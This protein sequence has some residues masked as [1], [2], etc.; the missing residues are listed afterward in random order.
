MFDFLEKL[1][2]KP[3]RTKKQIAFLSA[4]FFVGIIFVM[5]LSVIFPNWRESQSKEAKASEFPPSPIS[6]FL[7]TFS[8]GISAISEEFS[9][10]KDSIS[11]L[12]KAQDYYVST[13]T[14]EQ[15]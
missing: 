11:S 13:T 4:L 6:A 14:N 1:R 10:L 3:D 8:S 7:G 5:W 2:A 12:T 9:K 15:N